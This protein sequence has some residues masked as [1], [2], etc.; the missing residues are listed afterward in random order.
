[1]NIEDKKMY[2]DKWFSYLQ[3]QICKQFE[4]IEKESKGL[5][6]FVSTNWQKNNKGGG[7]T[8]KILKS[9]KI[10]E[11]VGVNKSTVSGIFS[12]KFRKNI[13]GAQTNGKYWASGISVVAH[14]RNPR[15]PKEANMANARAKKASVNPDPAPPKDAAT[16]KIK[17]I[18]RKIN[19]NFLPNS[20]SPPM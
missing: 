2:L 8:Y 18:K 20:C 9:G 6:K 5:Q 1:M 15:I 12:K 17:R 14:M 7:G 19:A 10:F 16:Q 4:K 11:K 13:P 3:S